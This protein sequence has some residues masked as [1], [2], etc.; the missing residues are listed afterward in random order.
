VVARVAAEVAH[1][2]SVPLADVQEITTTNAYRLFG[3]RLP[4]LTGQEQ[5]GA[6]G[7]G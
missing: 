1:L 6:T 3:Q 2:K 4:H 7:T 5:S